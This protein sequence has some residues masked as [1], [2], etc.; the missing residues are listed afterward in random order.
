MAEFIEANGVDDIVHISD[1]DL[2]IW[3]ELG[4]TSQP[5]WAYIN[6]DGTV[7]VEIGALGE[8]GILAKMSELAAA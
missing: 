1:E 8:E 6:D 7:E 2:E 5:A 3:R 4:V